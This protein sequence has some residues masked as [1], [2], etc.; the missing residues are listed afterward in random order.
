MCKRF[1]DGL[2]EDI[3][4]LVGILELKEFVVLVD[5]ALKAEELN[6]ERRKAAIEARD[7][8][9]R[10]ISKPFQSQPKRSKETNPRMTVSIGDSHRDRGRAYSGSKAQA[11]SVSSVG[12]V[13][14]RKPEC[15]QC[16]RQHYG[17]CWGTERACFRCGSR[18]HFIRDC[19]EKVKEE[20]FQSARQNTTA[21]RGRPPRNTGGGT[22]SKTVMKDLTAR[23]EARAPARAYAIRAR[24]DASSPDV[25]TGTFLSMILL[26]L[27]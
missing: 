8:R 21:S 5:R 19:P 25:I 3:K 18:E 12:N 6:K 2:N 17:E 1:E 26:L 4:V 20:R 11:T 14:P 7:V 9:K 16:G 23:S 13:R 10:Q 27:H 24:E 15:Q 22:S